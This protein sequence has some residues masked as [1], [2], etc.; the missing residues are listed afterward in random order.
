MN[1]F[2]PAARCDKSKINKSA[3]K[4]LPVVC[5]VVPCVICRSAR[6]FLLS[7]RPS[8]TPRWRNKRRRRLTNKKWKQIKTNVRKINFWARRRNRRRKIVLRR[9][10][11]E[12]ITINLH[13]GCVFAIRSHPSSQNSVS[14]AADWETISVSIIFI[15]V[16]PVQPHLNN[17]TPRLLKR[18]T[19]SPTCRLESLLFGFPLLFSRRCFSS[20][21]DRIIYVQFTGPLTHDD[22]IEQRE[23]ETQ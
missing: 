16:L 22:E 4:L 18:L 13:F 9:P 7:I 10:F 14:L 11:L 17:K 5:R 12:L 8:G 1:K 21:G 3:L 19:C 20:F 15:E 2:Y 23:M 6:G